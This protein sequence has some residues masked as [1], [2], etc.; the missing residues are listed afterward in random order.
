MSK[1]TQAPLD[2]DAIEALFDVTNSL[3]VS[4]VS[5]E[6]ARFALERAWWRI[7]RALIAEVRRLR[8]REAKLR[9]LHRP[10]AI[11]DACDHHHAE[12]DEPN[13]IVD[14]DDVG[15]TCAKMYDICKACCTDGD[16]SQ[17]EQC[18]DH[19]HGLNIPICKTREILDA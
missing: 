3:D 15:I 4:E 19:E 17:T 10:W 12:P 14:I 2:L 5:R 18:L 13:G 7:G 16:G 9:E 8:E 11:Y 6:S 1:P